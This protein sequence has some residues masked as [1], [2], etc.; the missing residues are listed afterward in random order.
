MD[1]PRISLSVKIIILMTLTTSL[2]STSL[3]RTSLHG[4]SERV[5]KI[6]RKF[7]IVLSN[8]PSNTLFNQFNKLKDPIPL[9]SKSN[10]VYQLNCSEC[11]NVYIGETKKTIE[12]ENESAY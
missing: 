7:N 10:V 8:K 3:P 5:N 2:L 12:R 4:T 1:T 9:N 6:L 11:N